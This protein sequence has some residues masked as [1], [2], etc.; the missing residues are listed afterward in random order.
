[1]HKLKNLIIFKKVVTTKRLVLLALKLSKSVKA[2]YG[3]NFASINRT[4]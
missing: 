1:M 2:I 4:I 3:F